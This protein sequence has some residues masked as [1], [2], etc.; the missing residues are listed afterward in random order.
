M[1]IDHKGVVIHNTLVQWSPEENFTDNDQ[2]LI[3]PDRIQEQGAR[4]TEIRLREDQLQVLD[5][6]APS[7]QEASRDFGFGWSATDRTL[8]INS[9]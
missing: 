4:G 7:S 8:T 5:H 1:S 9:A 6:W 3:L 2:I